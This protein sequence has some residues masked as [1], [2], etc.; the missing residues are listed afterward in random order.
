[1][2]NKN[3][4]DLSISI[5]NTSN[6]EFLRP[7]LESIEK[8]VIGI[9]YEILIVDNLST[10][11]SVEKI[12]KNFPK[13]ILS[14]NEKRFGF[15]KNNNINLRKSSGRYLMLLNDDTLVIPNSIEKA[16]HFL[17][18]N[19]NVGMVGCRMISPDGNYQVASA[20]RIRSLL[21]ELLIETGIKRNINYFQIDN[22]I[23]T[24]EIEIDLPSEAGMIVRREAIIQVG[25]LDEDFFMYGE[26]AEWCRRIKRASW[27]IIFLPD[28]PI[29]HFG[30]VTNKR[31]S[32]GMYLQFYKSTYLYFRKDKKVKSNIYKY[33]IISI[34]NLKRIFVLFTINFS[35]EKI[36]AEKKELLKYYEPL[37]SMFRY[38]LLDD[39]YP[40]PT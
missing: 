12:K 3:C 39:Q 7:C 15:A 38:K 18:C 13:V 29:V 4:V 23:P 17:D 27:K 22:N 31:N 9:S 2:N 11:G 33:F 32:L 25:L 40:F 1:M 19:S 28:T 8:N 21:S 16:I 20:R 30:N 24:S 10:D 34:F 37:I 26:G 36:K 5:V 6:W 35:N 14:V